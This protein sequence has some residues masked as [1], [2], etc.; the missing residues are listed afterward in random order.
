MIVVVLYISSPYLFC[1]DAPDSSITNPDP[2]KLSIIGGVTTGGFIYGHILSS[3]L[4]WKGEKSNFHF[5]WNYDW[6]YALGSDKFGHFYFPYLAVNLYTQAFEWAGLNRK[7][8]MWY[9]AS[10]ALLYQTYVE[11]KD[12][13]SAQWGFSWGDFAAN[14]A[15]ALYPLLQENS[16][17]LR[18]IN[19]KMSYYPSERFRNN[20]HKAI[21]DDY[22]SSYN[23]I[24]FD[25]KN[26]LP[27]NLK[28]YW[29]AFI[30]LTIGH[31][32]KRLDISN[33]SYH[34]LFVGLDWNLEGLPGDHWLL[35]LLKKNLNFYHLPA[36]TI[37][38]LP[39]IIWYGLKF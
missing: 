9:S 25:V 29:P 27:D 20:S 28:S 5:E 15:G 3:E 33:E 30:N 8:S 22:E 2:L 14:T 39:G 19:F 1:Q 37:R 13:F 11:I 34:E 6:S 24:T 26:F 38:I 18:N 21:I 35:K 32:V 31:S 7:Q 12:G 17:L 16:E 4:W 23:W 10:I 36:P